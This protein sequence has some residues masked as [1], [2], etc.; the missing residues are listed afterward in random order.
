MPTA[1]T[2]HTSSS[3]SNYLM[4]I[5]EQC[6]EILKMS[7]FLFHHESIYPPISYSKIL[8]QIVEN[9]QKLRGLYQVG[10]PSSR[11]NTEVK[12]LGPWLALG[13][14]TIQGVGRGCCSYKYCIRVQSLKRRTRASIN[15]SGAK[16]SKKSKIFS[17]RVEN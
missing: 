1:A 15:A 3:I 13:W 7:K 8:S 14:V 5:N 10:N 4:F 16:K 6:H 2:A 17:Q 11:Q 9:L 12:Q